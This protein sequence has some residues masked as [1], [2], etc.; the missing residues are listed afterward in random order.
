MPFWGYGADRLY[1]S[2]RRGSH[3]IGC[4]RRRSQPAA[5]TRSAGSD[6]SL[7]GRPLAGAGGST[8]DRR[9][10]ATGMAMAAP[11]PPPGPNPALPPQ[12]PP[13]APDTP[14]AAPPA[15]NP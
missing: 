3:A 6:R 7:V 9:Q 15:Q 13:T 11:L 10:P 1:S 12:T 4:D 14:P 5:E 2:W 8:P